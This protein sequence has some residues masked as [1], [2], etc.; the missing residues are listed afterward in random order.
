VAS[1][2]VHGIFTPLRLR[3]HP[4]AHCPPEPSW[5][6]AAL[7][8]EGDDGSIVDAPEARR[9]RAL[10]ARWYREKLPDGLK[11]PPGAEFFVH[12]ADGAGADNLGLRAPILALASRDSGFAFARMIKERRI[13]RVLLVAV[14][15]ATGPDPLRD[16]D[17]G[18]PS[19]LQSMRDA[20]DGLIRATSEQTLGETQF[21]FAQL[22]AAAAR[23][24]GSP[25]FYGPVV[26][27]FDAVRDDL[28][29]R[30]FKR[31]PTTLDLPPAEIDAL[32]I[33]GRTVLAESSEF[34]RFFQEQSG[35]VQD[36]RAL[37]SAARFCSES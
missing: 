17:R 8:G 16:A 10:L 24:G 22:R 14:N 7:L 32:R 31:I 21:V 15:A 6:A 37:P 33:A 36:L 23:N 3:N 29:R 30:C 20:A 5:I 2:A 18:G 25:K 28:Q 9:S 27:G 13:K 11:A 12:L 26:I 4:R 35:D 34:R 19:T 1:S